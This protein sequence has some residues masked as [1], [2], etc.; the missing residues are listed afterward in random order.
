MKTLPRAV[1]V[2]N[3]LTLFLFVL[4]TGS[5]QRDIKDAAPSAQ[6][7]SLS[8]KL[9]QLIKESGHSVYIPVNKSVPGILM[10][11]RGNEIKTNR[12]A[13]LLTTPDEIC[14]DPSLAVVGPHTLNGVNHTLY[15]CQNI[16]HSLTVDWTIRSSFDLVNANP[17]TPSQ[18]SKGRL[19]I[20]SGTTITFQ[21]LNIPLTALTY[22]GDDPNEP[23]VKLYHLVYTKNNI[24]HQYLSP[25]A[26]TAIEVSVVVYSDCTAPYSTY[27]ITT[28]YVAAFAPSIGLNPCE[29]VDQVY[30]N[31]ATSQSPP[32]SVND[33]GSIAGSYVVGSPGPCQ[34]NTP[35]MASQVQ[36][37]KT[38]DPDAN[39]RN[40]QTKLPGTTTYSTDGYV[41]YWEIRY[42]KQLQDYVPNATNFPASF[43]F[44]WRN[45][46]G[47][48]ANTCFGP[49]ANPV[50]YTISDF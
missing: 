33:C 48:G 34:N 47:T 13:K 4:L 49:W 43:T 39:Y 41:Y 37:K 14:D 25:G 22:T 12:T 29:R 46:D 20:K 35:N 1:Y 16:K 7:V 44:R 17:A 27:F 26:F 10:D 5:C 30:I 9:T 24:D 6:P 40:I 45:V 3:L 19:R 31:P 23:G 36:V 42:I 32:P 2:K 38:G 28:P 11:A 8:D 50:N 21:D 15:D 18:I